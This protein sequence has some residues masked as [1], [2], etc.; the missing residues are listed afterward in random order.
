MKKSNFTI[1]TLIL[2]VGFT[3][4]TFAQDTRAEVLGTAAGAKLVKPMTLTEASPLHFGVINITAA[5]V[6]G[7]VI[8]PSNSTT[9]SFTGGLIGSPV[10]PE[11]T[12]AA[13]TVT[14][15]KNSTYALSLPLTIT[16]TGTDGEG[17][18]TISNL[19]AR[20]TNINGED[21]DKVTSKLNA[22]GED[23][24]KVG[25]TLTIPADKSPGI[26]AGSFD[27]SVD[28]N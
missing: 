5:A 1:A 13:Y 26:F 6:G 16:V 7:T 18:L 9:R 27:V 20:F 11:A 25:G 10:G 4:N 8:L 22:S 12:N 28:Y 14:G 15:T 17:T 3:T 24:F 19:K 23:S 21:V 2:L